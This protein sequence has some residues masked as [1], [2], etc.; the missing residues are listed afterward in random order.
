MGALLLTIRPVGAQS[1]GRPT[2][3]EAP[4]TFSHAEDSEAAVYTFQA[5]DPEGKGIFWTLSGTDAVDFEMVGTSAR[6]ERG[7][8]RFKSRPDFEMP[9]DRIQTTPSDAAVNNIYNVTVR[10]SDGGAP[11]GE[12]SVTVTVTNVEEDGMV[13]LS[14]LQ[15][16]VGSELTATVTDPDTNVQAEYQ[17]SKSGT[18]G[19]TP[20]DIVDADEMTYIPTVDDVGSYLTV[21]ARYVDG[22]GSDIDDPVMA[23]S[24]ESVRADTTAND[25]PTIPDQNISTT[26]VDITDITRY[27]LEN[28]PPGTEVGPPVTAVDDDLDELTYALGPVGG[29]SP[30]NE[31]IADAAPFDIDPVTGQ[32]TTNRPLEFFETTSDG[33]F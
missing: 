30:T 33:V 20:T 31:Q 4:A 13:M 29:A 24:T 26:D 7:E 19:G 16:Q 15:P 23:T 2:I 8:L 27:V 10:F 21:T 6:S 5:A 32:I 3:D 22:H 9:T 17:W 14:P 18:R 25:I 12:H 11:A 1:D 28:M